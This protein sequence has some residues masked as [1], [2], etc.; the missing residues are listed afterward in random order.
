M[1]KV[2]TTVGTSIFENFLEK[3]NNSIKDKY[4]DL[5]EAP[6]SEWDTYKDEINM[7][8]SEV[9]YFASS[10]EN[11]FAEIT[12][13]RK[14]VELL[15][16]ENNFKVFLIT[17]DTVLSVLSAQLINEYVKIEKTSFKKP[18]IIQGLQ[19][20]NFSEFDTTGFYNLVS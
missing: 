11:A 6:Y 17:T 14:V 18:I 2:I 13:L 7:I 8:K 20:S 12:T 4:N 15:E 19:V 10:D 3:G 5:K 9:E 1:V 16:D